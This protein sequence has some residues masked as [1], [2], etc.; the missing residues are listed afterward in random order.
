VIGE[1]GVPGLTNRRIAAA[2]GV[3]LGSLTYHFPSQ[4]RRS[5]GGMLLFAREETAR[6][7]GIAEG[8]SSRGADPGG[9]G[10]TVEQVL[11]SMT[12]GREDIAR[13]SCSS[14][15]AATPTCGTPRPAVLR[16][17]NDLRSTVLEALN[18]PD[19]ALL[20]GPVVALI[21]GLQLRRLATG[22]VGKTQASVAL[23]ML[24]PAPQRPD[25]AVTAKTQYK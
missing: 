5:A 18:V 3:S 6:L 24:S 12:F 11:E 1:Q 7:A 4:N 2:A 22:E 8:A 17:T 25:Q 10:R 16:R 19:P 15:P 9:R 14:R 23:T 13:W 20:A 21:A